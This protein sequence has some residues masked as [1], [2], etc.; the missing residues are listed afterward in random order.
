MGLTRVRHSITVHHVV[1]REKTIFRNVR[2][3]P[4]QIRYLTRRADEEFEGNFSAATRRAV[5]DA[6]LLELARQEYD[7]Q[8]RQGLEIPT[9]HDDGS[10]NVLW[11][12]LSTR[13][14][15]GTIEWGEE[16]AALED[17]ESSS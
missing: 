12:I 5:A 8:A 15:G 11:S 9:S 10:P 17:D 14:G 2:F 4:K 1:G 7:V 3:T 16:P 13:F 6:R